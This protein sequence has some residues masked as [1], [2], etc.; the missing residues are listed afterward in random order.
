M[1][2]TRRTERTSRLPWRRWAKRA[3]RAWAASALIAAGIGFLFETVRAAVGLSMAADPASHAASLAVGGAVG[4][5]VAGALAA[6]LGPQWFAIICTAV[7]AVCG[8]AYQSSRRQTAGRAEVLK[9][10][11]LWSSLSL[12]LA[13]AAVWIVQFK[14]GVQAPAEVLYPPLVVLIAAFGDRIAARVGAYIDAWQAGKAP[15]DISAP[16]ATPAKPPSLGDPR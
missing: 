11:A 7:G 9:I 6:A 14:L 5:V 8:A 13:G 4:S 3:L 16:P 15:A 1:R 12:S 2:A 10:I